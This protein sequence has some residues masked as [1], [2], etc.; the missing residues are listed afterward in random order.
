MAWVRVETQTIL[1]MNEH[2]I[3]RN[4]RIKV[5]W[6]YYPI[7]V[8][9]EDILC[10]K[11]ENIP[12]WKYGNIFL[13]KYLSITTLGVPPW[14]HRVASWH[15]PSEKARCWVVYVPGEPSRHMCPYMVYVVYVQL[16]TLLLGHWY[17]I[18]ALYY[19][20]SILTE[21]SA[22]RQDRRVLQKTK[23]IRIEF[24]SKWGMLQTSRYV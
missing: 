18:M 5:Q 8:F 3:T 1:T 16:C 14:A 6:R 9:D 17:E 4:H 20:K 10:S 2:V 23:I 13:S 21:I 24:L 7:E 19:V 12:W 11:Y 15:Q 22:S